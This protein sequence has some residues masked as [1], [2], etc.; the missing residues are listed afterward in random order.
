M[1]SPVVETKQSKWTTRERPWLVPWNRKLR[2]LQSI[3]LRNLALVLV[4]SRYRGKVIDD[5]ALPNTL[6]SPAKQLA[7]RESRVLG[8]SKSSDELR[9]IHEDKDRDSHTNGGPINGSP[10]KEKRT[11][12][13]GAKL[14]RRSTLEW[15]S[16]TPQR[17]QTRLEAV[18]AARLADVFYTLHVANN[19]EPVYV[20]EEIKK[21]MNPSFRQ[22]DWDAC[23][24]GIT[25]QEEL[26]VKF[27]VRSGKEK[28]YQ[29]LLDMSLNLR[30]LQFIGKDLATFSHPFPQ[31]C[32]I[33]QLTDGYYTC[34][35]DAQV[36]EPVNP[37]AITKAKPSSPRTIRSASFDALLR[38]SKLDDSI[39]DALALRERL[40][41]DLNTI[42]ES[43]RQAL[44]EST[45]IKEAKDYLKTV[46]Y[47]KTTV[48]KQ[49]RVLRQ[50]LSQKRDSLQKR[51]DLLTTGRTEQITSI[52]QLTSSTDTLPS[53]QEDLTI[54]SKSITNQRRRIA[55]DLSRIYPIVPLP[56]KPLSF[57]IR[58]LH[59]PDS[60][61]LDTSTPET[62]SA[63]LGHASH[64]LLLLSFYLSQP[65][66]YPPHPHS[67]TSTIT[68]PISNIKSPPTS[69]ASPSPYPT[70]PL[71][72]PA[73]ADPTRTFPLHPRSGPKFRFEYALFLLNKDIQVL[74]SNAFNVRVLDIRQTLPNL[75]Y[76]VAC[77]GA[78][79][80]ELPGRKM[81]G[82]RGLGEGEG[83]GRAETGKGM[84]R[85][86]FE[87]G[88]WDRD[89]EGVWDGSVRMKGKGRGGG[90][91]GLGIKGREGG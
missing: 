19:K 18:S 56:S 14:R 57:T 50:T 60:E 86:E 47:A 24:P 64:T 29:I 43:N 40:S 25:R 54:L 22:I 61:D 34:F 41:S 26:R 38:L 63:A 83:K 76:V 53:L 21:S 20:S 5:D 11:R 68:D 74:L 77:M 71:L 65:L 82:V 58:S 10:K 84:T 6:K 48:E 23:G 2:H 15:A 51:R 44:E 35:T 73:L 31:N 9:P 91:E 36:E 81:G 8:H 80:G 3:A 78:G 49:L 59:L 52:S 37:F 85:E 67:S 4:D 12:P 33:F 87:A 17:R 28:S 90:I 69:G 75:A 72:P 13:V 79:E 88:R 30:S 39:Q 89:G 45:K 32:V 42:V 62:I 70:S 66:P 46:E 1:A 27:W 7:L 16:E 55:H